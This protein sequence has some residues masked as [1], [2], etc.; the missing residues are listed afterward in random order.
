M[1]TIVSDPPT[2]EKGTLRVI[3]LGGLGEIG[4]NMTV[5]EFDGSDAY[6]GHTRTIVDPPS[7]SMSS[8]ELDV[9]GRWIG[10]CPNDMKPGDTL[11]PSGMKINPLD[12]AQERARRAG[13]GDTAPARAPAPASAPPSAPA[14]AP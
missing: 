14:S 8:S 5:F 12:E 11:T 9:H 13:A 2:L 4:R 10:Q 3:P 1:S 6:R 7:R